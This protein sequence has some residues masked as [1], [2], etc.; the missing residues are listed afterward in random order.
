[1]VRPHRSEGQGKFHCGTWKTK[2][3]RATLKF[4]RHRP[5]IPVK[6][7]NQRPVDSPSLT[8]PPPRD[9][10]VRMRYGAEV[11]RGSFRH[12]KSPRTAC[13]PI[14]WASAGFT[15]RS[16]R[17]GTGAQIQDSFIPSTPNNSAQS[18]AQEAG[19]FQVSQVAL[20]A[21]AANILISQTA[22]AADQNAAPALVAPDPATHA[23]APQTAAAANPNPPA[24][25]AQQVAANPTVQAAANTAGTANIQDQLQA[26]NSALAALGLSNNDIS[27]IDRIAALIQDFSPTAF[28][29]LVYQLEALANQVTQQTP[30]NTAANTATNAN[31]N[32]GGFQVQELAIKFAGLQ[33]TVNAG[34]G[35]GA[36]QGGG[37]NKIQITAASLQIEEVQF[38]LA[39]GNGQILQVQA[40]QQN[41]SGATGTAQAPQTQVAA[42]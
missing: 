23:G 21:V 41:A 17:A 22:P 39:N 13:Q 40:P 11:D 18:A 31:A 7:P 4:A 3:W 37:A 9:T 2:T 20:S 10:E 29:S 15:N 14:F 27:Q 30:A 26:L 33:E 28:T 6:H 38:T 36:G 1:M 24:T 32:G 34:G 35:N 25:A 19:L 42:A 5:I 12:W 16:E 8:L